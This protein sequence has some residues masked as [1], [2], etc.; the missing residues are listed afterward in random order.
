[1]TLW[2]EIYFSTYDK[3]QNRYTG[4][5]VEYKKFSYV[6]QAHSKEYGTKLQQN[7][8]CCVNMFLYWLFSFHY[9]VTC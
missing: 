2:I 7:V 1:M 6:F 3:N 4:D 5:L 8:L 9:T